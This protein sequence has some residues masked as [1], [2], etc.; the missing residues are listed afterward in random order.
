MKDKFKEIFLIVLGA[1]IVSAAIALFFVPN[2]I[3]NGGVSGASTILYYTLKIPTGVSYCVI[4]AALLLCGWR[5]L[6]KEFVFKTLAVATLVSVLVQL[7]SYFPPA[8]ENTILA[9]LFGAALYGTGI[10]LTLVNGASTGGTDIVGRLIQCAAPQ[11]SIGSAILMIDSVVI[12]A[13]LICFRTVDLAM[14]GIL[15]LVISSAAIDRLIRKLNISKLA[16]IITEHGEE[17]CQRL[18]STSPRGVTMVDVIGGYTNRHKNML[19]CALKDHEVSKFQQ[20][21]LEIDSEA[22]IIFSESQQIIGNGF[23]VYY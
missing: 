6:G 11:A 20:K 9:A 18:V 15:S 8:T 12:A 5:Y 16:F 1:T 21:I 23:Y 14:L 4:N 3:V 22:F 19:I 17:I 13:S 7:F 2:K 10:A